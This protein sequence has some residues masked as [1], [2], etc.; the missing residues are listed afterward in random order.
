MNHSNSARRNFIRSVLLAALAAL[1]CAGPLPAAEEFSFVVAGDMQDFAAG[2][3]AGKRYFDGACEAMRRVGPGAF[4]L[5]P[6]DINPP[7]PLRAT[8]DRYLGPD[9]L[10]YVAVGNHEFDAEKTLAWVR[11]QAVAGKA[12]STVR[13]GG[14]SDGL[15]FSFDSGPVH[16]VA[17]DA[18]PDGKPGAKGKMDISD[19]AFAWLENDL[20]NTRQPLIFVTGHPP[21]V[22]QPDM[23]SGRVRHRDDSVSA[24]PSRVARFVGL[25]KKYHVRAYLGGHTHNASVAKVRGIWQADS[26]HTRGAGDPGSPSTFLKIRVRGEQVWVDIFRADPNGVE[27]TLRKTVQLD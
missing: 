25:L 13:L 5:T 3:P 23:D 19:A 12:P 9:F 26:G 24:D 27:Y 17:I 15:Y 6:G 8:I 11:S 16:F 20:A 7:A 2:A 21:I 22:S 4:L 10:W 1:A 18:Y 14:P